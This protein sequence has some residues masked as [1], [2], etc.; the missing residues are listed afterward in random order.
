MGICEEGSP[1]KLKWIAGFFY[2]LNSVQTYFTVAGEYGDSTPYNYIDELKA[3]V[4]GGLNTANV[5]FINGASGIVNRGCHNP[6]N[7]GTGDPHE[8]ES[9]RPTSGRCW[10]SWA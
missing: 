10:A 7:C 6:P 8:R 4:D 5:R 2:W 3:W 9:G 1:P